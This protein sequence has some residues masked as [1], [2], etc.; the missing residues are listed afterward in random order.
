MRRHIAG[1][2]ANRKVVAARLKSNI[3]GPR[4]EMLADAVAALAVSDEEMM[5]VHAAFAFVGPVERHQNGVAD[6]A[7]AAI[8]NQRGDPQGWILTTD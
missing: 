3:A 7:F 4:H 5:Q 6:Q 2:S 8:G 1:R